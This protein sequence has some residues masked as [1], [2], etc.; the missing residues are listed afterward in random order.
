MKKTPLIAAA[1]ITVAFSAL[2]ALASPVS[3]PN[4]DHSTVLTH[5]V[6][7][8]VVAQDQ[9]SDQNENQAAPPSQGDQGDDNGQ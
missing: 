2:P 5:G 1:A 3:A 4:A 6:N 8:I 9:P 7:G